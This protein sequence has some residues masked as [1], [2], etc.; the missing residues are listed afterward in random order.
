MTKKHIYT[1]LSIQ[2]ISLW[3]A[4][5]A[6]PEEDLICESAMTV[7]PCDDTNKTEPFSNTLTRKQLNGQNDLTFDKAIT[8][9]P[10]V[11]L[12]REKGLG[13]KATIRIRGA[14]PRH[15]PVYINGLKPSDPSTPND[16][17]VP[18]HIPLSLIDKIKIQRGP[19]SVLYGDGALS[20][21]IDLRIQKQRCRE[22]FFKGSIESGIGNFGTHRFGSDMHVGD[23]LGSLS[24]NF[25]NSG[26]QGS[27]QSLSRRYSNTA[28]NLGMQFTPLENSGLR[29]NVTILDGKGPQIFSK[30]GSFRS[31]QTF[32]HIE[33]FHEKDN[34]G[35]RLIAATAQ[36]ERKFYEKNAKTSQ[37]DGQLFQAHYKAWYEPCDTTKL[38]FGALTTHQHAKTKTYLTPEPSHSAHSQSNFAGYLHFKQKLIEHVRFLGGIRH[39]IYHKTPNVTD[40]EAELHFKK[41]DTT[42]AVRY[43]TGHKNPSLFQLF[44]P[45]IGNDNLIQ[46]KGHG[47]DIGVSQGFLNN[48]LLVTLSGFRT[49][50]HNFIGFEE[51]RYIQKQQLQLKGLELG[52][53]YQPTDWVNIRG[54]YSLT[55][56][57]S[58]QPHSAFTPKHQFTAELKILPY[59]QVETSLLGTYHTGYQSSLGNLKPTFLLHGA[60]SIRPLSFV[61]M[62][63]R[64]D[65]ILN[66]PNALFPGIKAPG[67]SFFLNIK[68]E[69]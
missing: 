47:I 34:A 18:D 57:L 54:A 32:A 68:V 42:A 43:G 51:N 13:S 7:T 10:G 59:K 69:I 6:K 65:N 44:A 17:F 40:A 24:M 26:T 31:R 61:S 49:A 27:Q 25:L 20:G 64:L 33:T 14:E 16:I 41:N 21:V 22:P 15:S 56:F 52:T 53:F 29:G 3:I 1:F 50:I 4:P 60:V 19:R 11:T 5:C 62:G 12:M 46:E 9:V 8:A 36:S 38:K 39:T 48:Q 28:G 63:I 30:E 58:N 55:T 2:F 67:R 66:N 45:E 23:K 37:F 35:H